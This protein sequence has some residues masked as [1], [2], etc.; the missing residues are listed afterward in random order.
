MLAQSQNVPAPLNLSIEDLVAKSYFLCH[1]IGRELDTL[2]EASN[3]PDLSASHHGRGKTGPAGAVLSEARVTSHEIVLAG[4][5]DSVI[6]VSMGSS[7]AKRGKLQP[8]QA[9]S[10]QDINKSPTAEMPEDAC[11][12]RD[13][14]EVELSSSRLVMDTCPTETLLYMDPTNDRKR[15]THLQH[16]QRKLGRLRASK[17][18]ADATTTVCSKYTTALHLHH[19]E[20]TLMLPLR[21]SVRHFQASCC[22]WAPR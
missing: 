7:P 9:V 19:V 22:M 14:S 18:L 16:W 12:D 10:S 4:Q 21:F 2:P 3:S 5:S 13:D 17:L 6:P 15:P 1:Q 8:E 11:T 20:N